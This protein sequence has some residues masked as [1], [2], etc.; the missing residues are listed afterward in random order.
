MC[1][2]EVADY[3]SLSPYKHPIFL[4]RQS[5]E[6]RVGKRA[7]FAPHQPYQASHIKN[8]L[9]WIYNEACIDKSPISCCQWCYREM[10]IRL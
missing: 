5:E 3:L 8:K 2:G 9:Q 10:G 7:G 4:D 1:Y 6:V